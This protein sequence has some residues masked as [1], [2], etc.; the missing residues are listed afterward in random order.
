MCMLVQAA[1]PQ[2]RSINDWQLLLDHLRQQI[3]QDS[4]NYPRQKGLDTYK[5][6][7]QPYVEALQV[8]AKDRDEA[9]KAA[10]EA[11]ASKDPKV[12][13]FF[14]QFMDLVDR[15]QAEGNGVL[16]LG[17]F[18]LR[19]EDTFGPKPCAE[20]TMNAKSFGKCLYDKARELKFDHTITQGQVRLMMNKGLDDLDTGWTLRCE[21]TLGNPQYCGWM[22]PDLERNPNPYDYEILLAE[23]NEVRQLSPYFDLGPERQR[24][25][26]LM[27]RYLK[28]TLCL[29]P[30]T[31]HKRYV[32]LAEQYK[33]SS[34][35]EYIDGFYGTL[36]GTVRVG[37]GGGGSPA[38]GAHVV[39]TDPKDETTWE[40]DTK[41]DGTY[42]IKK[43][44]LH[45]DKDEKGHPR[46]PAFRISAALENCRG[47]GTFTGTLTNP[48]PGEVLKK[49]VTM[50]CGK[51]DASM[52]IT[53]R[54][55]ESRVSESHSGVNAN[56]KVFDGLTGATVFLRLTQDSTVSVPGLNENLESYH[57]TSFELESFQKQARSESYSN[58]HMEHCL[59]ESTTTTK[60][61]GQQ[62][63][64]QLEPTSL[65]L[66]LMIHVDAKTQKAKKV[67]IAG[68]EL[69]FQNTIDV[70]TVSKGCDRT[71]S[72]HRT[73]L[74]NGVF[75][76]TPVEDAIPD[77]TFNPNALPDFLRDLS[78][79][80]GVQIPPIKGPKQE[81]IRP[82]F[83]VKSG[84]GKSFLEG[85]GRVL[86]EKQIED[87]H[88]RVEQI[89]RWNMIRRKKR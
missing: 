60:Q 48:N 34:A 28:D 83:V 14:D 84:D 54:E 17:S 30:N 63:G 87:G 5:N 44:L 72:N 81:S 3:D 40:A 31:G 58:E 43:A 38:E 65:P 76:I 55:T 61:L 26:D 56:R 12:K 70:D 46:C 2:Q 7:C 32:E 16:G 85:E 25:D 33:L 50:T 64:F 18:L 27:N 78:K 29:D 42:T 6:S 35:K 13:A 39:V 24:A 20:L 23:A 19:V 9:F 80:T 77:P 79:R 53:K 86:K 51:W 37:E 69:K 62:M 75:S 1:L 41:A 47:K 15:A 68:M 66:F 21:E 71:S 59:I 10:Q 4:Q 67:E 49:D 73:S 82:E 45:A 52:V 57:V 88:S 22:Y 89:Y 11:Q 36:K 74:E 8:F